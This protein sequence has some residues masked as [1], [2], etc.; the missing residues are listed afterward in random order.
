MRKIYI[1]TMLLFGLA[2]ICLSSCSS[3]EPFHKLFGKA[4]Q[5]W[6]CFES[7]QDI[8]IMRTDG[9]QLKN[10]TNTESVWE[11]KCKLSWD[12]QKV[13]YSDLDQNLYTID[14]N[15]TGKKLVLENMGVEY[16]S[17]SPD[18]STIIYSHVEFVDEMMVSSIHLL[19][20]DNNNNVTVYETVSGMIFSPIISPDGKSI[21]FVT[22][23]IYLMN[24]DGTEIEQIKSPIPTVLIN[25]LAWSKNGQFI[26][27]STMPGVLYGAESWKEFSDIYVVQI[28]SKS[29]TNYT[30]NEPYESVALENG[31][32]IFGIDESPLW[33][34]EH[35]IVFLSNGDSRS[36]T[37]KPYIMD[38]SDGSIELLFDQEMVGMDYQPDF[39]NNGTPVP[40]TINFVELEKI[41]NERATATIQALYSNCGSIYDVPIIPEWR[42]IECIQFDE[43][44]KNFFRTGEYRPY[45]ENYWYGEIIDG[46]YLWLMRTDQDMSWRNL[47]PQLLTDFQVSTSF[48]LDCK[49]EETGIGLVYD[50]S[51]NEGEGSLYAIF[52]KPNKQQYYVSSLIG[53][54]W[55]SIIESK[56]SSAINK[57]KP[58]QLNMVKNGSQVKIIINNI[59]V[60]S[61]VIDQADA[62]KTGLIARLEENDSN[63]VIRFDN[64]LLFAP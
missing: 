7:G 32:N 38:I 56:N 33:A 28:L 64:F 55:N 41:E 52:L 18:G 51:Q 27:F 20:V 4:Y 35:Q 45:F 62:G 61:F 5:G 25:Q 6:I 37:R 46:G 30:K 10:L 40:I 12:T 22:D 15:G 43:V 50:T 59:E 14:R 23:G 54:N 24:I 53:D 63:C 11:T 48:I 1:R 60:D 21:A 31:K 16:P 3:N 19:D 44:E 9:S 49:S 2:I 17:W 57:V 13:L 29:V 34:N 8:W 26:A 39:L 47:Y 36:Y 58:N 42:K